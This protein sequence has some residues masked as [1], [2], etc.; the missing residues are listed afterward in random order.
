MAPSASTAKK[1]LRRASKVLVGSLCTVCIIYVAVTLLL[2][3]PGVQR[4]TGRWVANGLATRWGTDI[5][6][7]R[8]NWGLLNRIIID[9]IAVRDRDGQP[10]LHVSRLSVSVDLTQLARGQVDI[11][12][13]QLFGAQ[14]TI[15]RRTAD[16]PLNCQ[17][18]IDALSGNDDNES[19]SNVQ[20]AVRT[21]LLRG[22]D[23]DYDVEDAPQ[24]PGRINVNHLHIK[25]IALTAAIDLQATTP[26]IVG[27]LD[28]KRLSG[29]ETASG[30]ALARLRLSVETDGEKV[31]VSPVHIATDYSAIELGASTVVLT[32]GDST[33]WQSV[34]TSLLPSTVAGS[35][36]QR[37]GFD[38]LPDLHLQ[39]DAIAWADG[40]WR[41]NKCSIRTGDPDDPSLTVEADIA[42]SARMSSATDI[43]LHADGNHLVDLLAQTGVADLSNS[44]LPRL[45]DIHLQGNASLQDSTCTADLLLTT[46]V[47][48]L[49]MQG[50]YDPRQGLCAKIHAEEVR[51]DTL[52]ASP[53]WGAVTADVDVQQVTFPKGGLPAGNV[54]GTVQTLQYRGYDYPAIDL[55]AGSDGSTA[56]AAASASDANVCVTLHA[57]YANADRHGLSLDV[58]VSELNPHALNLTDAYEQEHFRGHLHADIQG[59]SLKTATGT[60][61][62]DSFAIH[63]PD[64]AY[65]IAEMSIDSRLDDSGTRL[66][67][68]SGDFIDATLRSRSTPDNIVQVLLGQIAQRMPNAM[69]WA[70]IRPRYLAGNEVAN[71][72]FDLQARLTDP[73]AIRHLIGKD[74]Y[75]TGPLTLAAHSETYNDT[76]SMA[77]EAQGLRMDDGTL[78]KDI[79][80]A[81]V[82]NDQRILLE[83]SAARYIENGGSTY[84]QL[85]A[86]AGRDSLLTHLSI[87]QHANANLAT[88]LNTLTIFSPKNTPGGRLHVALLPSQLTVND[89]VWRMSHADIAIDHERLDVRNLSMASIYGDRFI[90]VNGT[91]SDQPEDSLL[92]DLGGIQ[93]EYVLDLI[94][95]HAVHF[96][97][98]AS[99]RAVLK[100]FTGNV[101]NVVARLRVDG[102]CLENA[103]FGTANIR[104]HWD[105]DLPGVRLDAHI[106]DNA[107]PNCPRVTNCAGYVAPAIKDIQLKVT[108]QHTNG[109]FL[110]DYLQSIFRDVNGEVNGELNIVGPLNEINIVGDMS[111]DIA[112]TLIPTGVTYHINPHDTLRM[113]PYRFTFDHVRI[114]DDDGGEGSVNGYVTHRNVKN[115]TYRF[116]ISMDNMLVYEEHAFNAD[117]FMGKVIVDGDLNINGSDGHPLYINAECTPKRGSFFAYDAATP[118]AATGGT[119]ITFNDAANDTLPVSIPQDS[120][121]DDLYKGDI[122]MDIALH[123]TPDCNIQLRM[124]NTDDGYITTQG[125]GELQAHYHNKSPFSLQGTYNI[126]TGSYRLYLQEII[127]RDL[128]LQQG[129]NVVFNGNPFD[130]DIHLICHHTLPAVP[131][132]DLTADASVTSTG[133]AKVVCILDITGQLGNM[134]LDFNFD[135]PNETEETKQ[136]VRSLV[137]T[138]EERNMQMVYLLA[139]GRFYSSEYARAYG[140]SANAQAVNNLIASTISGQINQMLS[141][142]IGTESNWNF[143]TGISTGDEGL[144]DLDVEGILSGRLFDDRLLINGN[145]G[146]RDNALTQNASFIGDFDVQWRLSPMGNTYLKAYNKAND[147]YFTK[148]SLNTQGIGISYQHD[149]DTWGTL[150]GRKRKESVTSH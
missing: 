14:A 96:K 92:V 104:A 51:L 109:A 67:E 138:D 91:V 22:C 144:E 93:V 75:L 111:A 106:V 68:V 132:S 30:I 95:F 143:G 26:G 36:L 1:W 81:I 52:L 149:F 131:L 113:R 12:T 85:Q 23:V 148:S 133:R 146:Y 83:A 58:A 60:V 17:F 117:K 44:P 47:G 49:S 20:L 80:L 54:Q 147:R 42:V 103:Y 11:T 99:G 114:S 108:A 57:T 66:T 79:S 77:L 19:P 46:D 134:A 139:L 128:V 98:N 35:D 116:D 33:A 43:S 41:L 87:Q 141:S 118:D 72:S 3:V 140:Q 38:V 59:R 124:D 70:G 65:H 29:T 2:H 101:P 13:V 94:N 110:G 4:S 84:A 7:G 123:L 121:P 21:L 53:Q 115:F 32:V 10:M 28:V 76:L 61:R 122:F 5:S 18:L 127:Y 73:A 78:Y 27:R 120:E 126:L 48:T 130:A 112:M 97:G 69:D 34:Q 105:H 90:N 9:D 6:V 71:G 86:Y 129:S 102:F 89:T 136:L 15:G 135:L 142:V 37:M 119:F 39:A 150:L 74:I 50:T 100:G 64:R 125:T 25:G 107:D 24:T 145:F 137:Y 63:T 8:I 16:A 40:T 55:R 56:T 62:L 31:T 88:T 45:A 82:G